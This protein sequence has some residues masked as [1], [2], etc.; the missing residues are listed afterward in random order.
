MPDILALLIAERD[1]FDRAIAALGDSGPQTQGKTA[2]DGTRGRG[3]GSTALQW[4]QASY[5]RRCTQ[6][7]VAEDEGVLG[8]G[9]E[10]ASEEVLNP[11]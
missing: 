8:T 2:E 11:Q 1:R 5:V 10:E 3:D 6:S 4:P 7:G 9:A